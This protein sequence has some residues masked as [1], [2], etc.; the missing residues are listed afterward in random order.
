[1]SEHRI[2]WTE[3]EML[4]VAR[5]AWIAGRHHECLD[6]IADLRYDAAMWRALRLRWRD[7]RRRELKTR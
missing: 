7:D 5:D 2:N 3:I 6:I 4:S 1:M